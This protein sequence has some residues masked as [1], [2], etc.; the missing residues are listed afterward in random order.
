MRPYN[1]MDDFFRQLDEDD[2][3]FIAETWS[4]IGGRFRQKHQ[5]AERTGIS[6]GRNTMIAAM[7]Q[8]IDPKVMEHVFVP[9]YQGRRRDRDTSAPE[10][11]DLA[12]RDG[13]ADRRDTRCHGPASQG[14]E[15]DFGHDETVIKTP[16][17]R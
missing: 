2:N 17:D 15:F 1:E 16:C 5:L 3:R 4:F 6:S 13:T 12:A 10:T 14:P 11:V 7:N 8:D 9:R